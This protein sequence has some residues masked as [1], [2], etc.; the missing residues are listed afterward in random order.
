MSSFQEARILKS[1]EAT[2]ISPLNPDVILQRFA[3][4][5]DSYKSSTSGYSGEDWRKIERLVR[6]TVDDQSS[7]QARK[8]SSSLHHISVQNELLHNEIKGLRKALLIKKKHTKKSKPLDLQQRQEYHGGAVFWSPRKIRE[9][10]VRQSIKEQEEKEQQLQKAETAELK[11]AAKLYKEKI[12][13]EKRVA[14][15]AAKVAREEERAKKAAE[16]A[17][18][19]EARNTAKAIKST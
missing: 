18:K 3:T 14:R 7:R 8:L 5:Q 2:S 13:Q 9:A 10:R 1:F 19:K 12:A 16:R 15:E 4:E 11:K 6:S 17:R